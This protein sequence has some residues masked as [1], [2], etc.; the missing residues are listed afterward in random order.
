M[1]T[2]LDDPGELNA[3]SD[4]QLVKDMTQVRIDGVGRDEQPV[5]D[6]AIGAARGRKAR[7]LKFSVA[8]RFPP[9]LRAVQ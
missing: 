5:G 3:G 9:E 8:E 7:N 4:L 2:L 1:R 6:P